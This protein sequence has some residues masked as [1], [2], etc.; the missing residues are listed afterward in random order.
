MMV[1]RSMNSEITMVDMLPDWIPYVSVVVERASTW[2]AKRVIALGN[3]PLAINARA[4][5]RR[6]GIIS[7]TS[8][9]R[10]NPMSL[11]TTAQIAEVLEDAPPVVF[12]SGL[13][14]PELVMEMHSPSALPEEVKECGPECEDEIVVS[15]LPGAPDHLPPEKEATLEVKEIN[16]ATVESNQTNEAK[17][18]LVGKWDWKKALEDGTDHFVVWIKERLDDVPKHSGYDKAGLERAVAYLEKLD[19]EI[20]KAMRLDLDGKLDA[21]KIEDVRS[22]IDDGVERLH[23]RVDKISKKKGKRKKASFDDGIVKEAQKLPSINGI[24]VVVPLLISRCARVCINGMVSAGHDMMD[25]YKQQV[26][27]FDLNI[28]EQAELQQL[29]MDMGYATASFDRGYLAGKEDRDL[30]VGEFDMM[31]SYQA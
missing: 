14:S 22:K 9:H 18:K 8:I 26:D 16:D 21:D 27:K 10:G 20:S 29:I 4:S 2:L 1:K 23:A 11:T 7:H 19:N 25:L 30:E 28:R 12:Y 6:S 17:D 31:S 3:V 24:T 15:E 13:P 5:E